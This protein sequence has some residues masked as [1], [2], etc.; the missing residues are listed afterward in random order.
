MIYFNDPAKAVQSLTSQPA[1][2]LASLNQTGPEQVTHYVQTSLLA[3]FLA[4]CWQSSLQWFSDD[5][6]LQAVQWFNVP[7]VHSAPS[8]LGS[9]T[10]MHVIGHMHASPAIEG[11]Q[12]S[13][14]AYR[15]QYDILYIQMTHVPPSITVA[16]S[17]QTYTLVI[18][19]CRA[20]L[21]R[22]CLFEGPWTAQ[23]LPQSRGL[24]W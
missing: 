20:H 16:T 24:Y 18:L 6:A 12:V 19:L 9:C 21:A 22:W 5:S 2:F 23:H 3:M 8:A 17:K 10:R 7:V 15:R 1:R 14:T 11:F 13:N 4:M